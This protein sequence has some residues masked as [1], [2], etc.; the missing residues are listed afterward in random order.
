MF[1]GVDLKVTHDNQVYCF[2]VNPNPGYSY[3]EV[4]TGQPISE[5]L[6]LC[7]VEGDAGGQGRDGLGGLGGPE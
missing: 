5:G 4:N 1:G 7:L 6:S 3:F 2:E